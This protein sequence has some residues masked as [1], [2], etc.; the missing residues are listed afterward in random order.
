LL[1]TELKKFIHDTSIELGFSHVG[2]SSATNIDKNSYQLKQWIDNGFHASMKWMENRSEERSD[3]FKYF[4]KAK[5]IISMSMNYFTGNASTEYGVGKIS[6]YAWGDDYHKIIKAKLLNILKLIKSKEPKINGI[7]CVDT[8]PVMEKAWAQKGGIGW[9]GKHTNLITK[10]HGSWIFLGEI[11][12]DFELEPDQEFIDDL[13]GSCTAC[14]DA[15]P[16]QA[17]PQ[18]YVLDSTKCISYLT[19][20]HRDEF[21]INPNLSN[22]IYGCDICQEVCPWNIKF[23][24]ESIESAFKPRE[25]FNNKTL[26][27]W[28]LLTEQEFEIIFKNSPIK[29]T[30]F[31]GLK[32]NISAANQTN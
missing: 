24:Q 1:P 22:W 8:S 28:E 12:I 16:T 21:D 26:N 15:C 2:F 32:R 30:K 20:E 17:F 11:I 25:G 10:S 5:T 6:N 18:P 23:S 29:R 9:I 31:K 19:I 27:D 3:I 13:C 4:P 7:A 14:L